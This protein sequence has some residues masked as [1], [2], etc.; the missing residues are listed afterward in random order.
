MRKRFGV[1]IVCVLSLLTLSACRR[2]PG[3]PP[4]LTGQWAQVLPDD[5]DEAPEYYHLARITEDRIEIY[6]YFVPDGS[7]NLYWYGT[8]TPPEDDT[9]PY[10]WTSENVLPTNLGPRLFRY[11]SR[12]ATK[13]FTYKKGEISYMIA[14]SQAL[15]M[16]VTLER[17]EADV[18]IR[19]EVPSEILPDTP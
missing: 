19:G 11:A 6:Y 18:E 9:E 2:E 5:S 13:D 17:P 14:P 1:L 12:D 4:D 15:R 10:V 16:N 8:F 7:S 3:P